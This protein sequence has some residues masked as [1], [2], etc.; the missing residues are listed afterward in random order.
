M[1][2]STA[3]DQSV[4]LASSDEVVRSTSAGK[5][6]MARLLAPGVQQS[7]EGGSPALGSQA[8]RVDASGAERAVIDAQKEAAVG[9]TDGQLLYARVPP[10]IIGGDVVLLQVSDTAMWSAQPQPQSTATATIDSH[11][12]S[13]Y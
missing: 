9:R 8:G 12:L 13:V 4:A 7:P 2:T 1:Y 5:A 10:G 11:S 6:S 3:P